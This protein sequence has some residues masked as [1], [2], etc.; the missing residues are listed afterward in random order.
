MSNNQFVVRKT[1]VTKSIRSATFRYADYLNCKGAIRLEVTDKQIILDNI[2]DFPLTT[3]FMSKYAIINEEKINDK[4][5]HFLFQVDQDI[6]SQNIF[7]SINNGNVNT[8]FD[9]KCQLHIEKQE[10][11]NIQLLTN[12]IKPANLP[13]FIMDHIFETSVEDKFQE[14]LKRCTHKLVSELLLLLPRD[15]YVTTSVGK[16]AIIYHYNKQTRL[17]EK[18]EKKLLRTVLQTVALQ[19]IYPKKQIIVDKLNELLLIKNKLDESVNE[20]QNKLDKNKSEPK[21]KSNPEIKKLKKELDE[22]NSKINS[23]YTMLGQYDNV[24][25]K[26]ETTPFMVNVIDTFIT[27]QPIFNKSFDEKLDKRMDVFNFINGLVDLK[28][29][30]FRKRTNDDY[31]TQTLN[32]D[33]VDKSECDP[34]I[35]QHIE[36]DIILRICND[37][38]NLAPIIYIFYE[39]TMVLS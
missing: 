6:N 27:E 15:Y 36:R 22:L 37:D 4:R 10:R 14:I 21:I 2:N 16:S 18:I 26:I 3:C 20:I 12:T 32:Y 9:G 39:N 8:I 11:S 17:Y 35:L 28:T 7:K 29:G 38:E 25:K 31:F 1:A 19:F 5:L 24:L 23:Y 30:L 13:K 33:W 34:Q